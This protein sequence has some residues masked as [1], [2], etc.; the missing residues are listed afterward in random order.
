MAE[1]NPNPSE[2]LLKIDR[3]DL[4][5]TAVGI[6]AAGIVP[7]VKSCEVGPVV[8]AQTLS[9]PPEPILKV[10]ATTARRLAEIESRNELRRQ[11]GLPLVS[12]VQEWRR[13]KTI[14]SAQDFANFV[15]RFRSRMQEKVLARIRRRQGD[16][17]WKPQGAFQGM[18]FQNDVSARMKRLY[19]RI[20]L[21]TR[22]SSSSV[23]VS[24]S[25]R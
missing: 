25:P 14:E 22:P 15:E 2:R 6:T 1:T 24:A 21:E 9:A 10:S 19:E 4:L 16:A 23:R 13:L 18:A 20:G 7:N 11:A 8:S 12:V 17:Q 3:R 5:S